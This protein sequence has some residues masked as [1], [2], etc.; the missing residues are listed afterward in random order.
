GPLHEGAHDEH[1][2]RAREADRD[3]RHGDDR[4]RLRRARDGRPGRAARGRER[5]RRHL[6]LRRQTF[7]V[8]TRSPSAGTVALCGTPPAITAISPGPSGADL[9]STT[10]STVPPS[11]THV[12]WSSGCSWVS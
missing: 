12:T 3:G 5:P 1:A 6:R 11:I 9:P 7:S 8:T 4:A 2:G 10:K